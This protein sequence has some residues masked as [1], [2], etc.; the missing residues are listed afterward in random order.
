MVTSF[1]RDKAV[2]C[3]MTSMTVCSLS[4][5]TGFLLGCNI[6]KCSSKTTSRYSLSYQDPTPKCRIPD[7]QLA[8]KGAAY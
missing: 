2:L 7:K 3:P 6:L 4:R 8:I 5:D 1:Y